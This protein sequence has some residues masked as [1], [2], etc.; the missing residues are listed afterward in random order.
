MIYNKNIETRKQQTKQEGTD[1]REII[2]YEQDDT[3]K[4]VKKLQ[5]DCRISEEVKKAL[6]EAYAKRKRRGSAT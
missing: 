5:F 1:M 3:S 6:K 4:V 2:S